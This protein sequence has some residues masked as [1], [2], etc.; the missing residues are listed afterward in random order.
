MVTKEGM[1]MKKAKLIFLGS[2]FLSLCLVGCANPEPEGSS[3]SKKSSSDSSLPVEDDTVDVFVLSGQS[4][5]EGSTYWYH[6]NNNTPLLE[7][8]MDEAELDFDMVNE[9][10]GIPNVLTSYYGFYYPNGWAQARSSSL[11]QSTSESKLTPYFE[12]TRVGMGVSDRLKA[13]GRTSYFFGPE[14]GLAYDLAEEATEDKP[15][16]LAKCAFSGSGFTKTDGPQWTSRE[17]DPAKSLFYLLKTYTKNCLD[18]IEET[19]KEP[20]LRGFLWHQ[21]ESDSGDANYETYLETLTT[22]FRNEFEDYAPDGEG[23]NI[24]FIDCTIYDSGGQSNC[25]KGKLAFA[26]RSEDDLNFC[27][28]ASST[29]LNLQ[30]GDD[31]KGGYNTWH[32]NTKDEFILGQAYAKVILDNDLL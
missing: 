16:Y 21:G 22:D 28:D 25:N 19:G 15:I 1:M 17:E 31:A 18:A 32:Y 3:H 27:I 7:Q 13:D 14:L 8:Y 2:A 4:N 29:G 30:R 12:P 23:D 9:D 26:N 10:K 6:P 20:V 5:M 11:D 24:A